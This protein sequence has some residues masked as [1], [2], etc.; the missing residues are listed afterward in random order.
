M[1][2]IALITGLKNTG[3]YTV[4]KASQGTLFSYLESLYTMNM[5]VDKLL[6]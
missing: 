2:S 5:D 6:V 1:L 4:S 3:K